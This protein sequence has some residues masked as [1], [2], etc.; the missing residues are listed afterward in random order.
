MNAQALPVVDVFDLA[1][2]QT[3]ATVEGDAAFAEFASLRL[4]LEPEIALLEE[5]RH[6]EELAAIA[7]ALAKPV[8]SSDH[9]PDAALLTGDHVLNFLAVRVVALLEELVSLL[10]DEVRV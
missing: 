2:V 3:L 7:A 6:V 5:E 1:E 4:R 10:L 8:N 9:G